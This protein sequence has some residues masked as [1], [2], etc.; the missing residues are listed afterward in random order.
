[1]KI[2]AAI[3]GSGIG[4][5][6]FEA[7]NNYK[8]SKVSVICEKNKKKISFLKKKYPNIKVI[9]KE[10]QIYSDKSINLVSI[11]SYDNYHFS[12]IIKCINFD[13]NI[14]VE[15]P[16]CL[17]LEQ[18]KKIFFL[19]KKKPNIKIISNLVLRT[20]ALFSNI[21]KN[22]N[23]KNIFYIEA[24]YIWG[25]SYKLFQWRSKTKEYSIVLGA[26]IHVIDL[27]MWIL[28]DKP[29]Y[30]TSYA[31]NIA[32]KNTSFKKNS[33]VLIVL[34][35]PNKILVKISANVAGVYNHFHEIKVFEKGKTFSHSLAGTFNFK[36]DKDKKIFQKIY[37]NYPD[38]KNRKKLIQNFI[39]SLQY[40]KIKPIVTLQEQVDL[41]NVCFAADKSIK[42]G[43]RIKINYL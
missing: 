31:N 19:L 22:I 9:S 30:V 8:K 36:M 33:F 16:M 23:L 11:A 32:T 13:K 43:N 1:M 7:I 37:S 15:K 40:K 38:K 3:I 5:K 27:V 42:T 25:R 21:K 12:Q 35:F 17:N 39:D 2:N 18:L 24:D 20:D 4:I 26:G 14:I 41:M 6:H 34:E 29:I 28:G 10:Q